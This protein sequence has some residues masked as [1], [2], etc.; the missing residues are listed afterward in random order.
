MLEKY[1]NYYTLSKHP[2]TL[3]SLLL[4]FIRFPLA[5]PG[6]IL[7]FLFSQNFSNVTL[8]ASNVKAQKPIH[9]VYTSDETD[10]KGNVIINL[11]PK[12][13]FKGLKDFWLKFSSSV[14]GV[15]LL[16]KRLLAYDNPEDKAHVD[17]IIEEIQALLEGNSTADKCNGVQFT[18]DE[19]HIKGSEG[20]D[21]KLYAY[22]Y[23]QI[24][25]K[26][27]K[28]LVDQP[29][30]T[31][32]E[33]FTLETPDGAVLDSV[34]VAGDKE[35]LKPIS[36]RKFVVSCMARDQNYVN[37][38][39]DFKHSAKQ[40]GCTVVGF[41]YR[42]IDYSKGMVW[43][44]ENLINDALAQ[45]QRLL[46][47]GA[48]PENIGLEGMSIGGAVATLTAARLHEQGIKVKLYNERSFRSLPRLITGYILPPP[49]SNPWNPI[50]WL[51]YIAAG[52][53][54]AIIL[55]IFWI[56]GW[57]MDAGSAW[58]KI[59]QEYKNFSVA[60]DH[61]DYDS[62]NHEED[63]IIHDSWAS[64]A[65]LVDENKAAIGRKLDHGTTINEEE[66]E[67]LFDQ[68]ENHEFRVSTSNED[69]IKRR[70]HHVPR[71]H[72]VNSHS[73][74]EKMHDH[75]I[76]DF[77][78]KFGPQY[79]PLETSINEAAIQPQVSPKIKR[80]LL[81]ASSGGGGHI[82]SIMGIIDELKAD[83][84][85]TLELTDHKAQ[86]YQHKDFSW[87]GLGVKIAAGIMSVPL[88]GDFIAFI[89]KLMGNPSLPNWSQL[90]E[91][92]NK[93]EK[94]ETDTCSQ[95]PMGRTRPYVDMLLDVMPIGYESAAIWN[96]LLRADR[97]TDLD[98]L[99]KQ[100]AQSDKLFYQTAYQA[101][102]K[103]LIDAAEKG[104]AYTEIISTQPLALDALCD[105]VLF[106]N[107]NYLPQINAE[108]TSPLPEVAIHQFLTD[109]P[110]L[111]CNHFLDSIANLSPEQQQQMHV[112]AVNFTAGVVKSYFADGEHFKGIHTLSPKANPMIRAG[113][114]DPNLK[115]YLDTSKEVVLKVK[116]YKNN[117][118]DDWTVQA[119]KKAIIIP[120]NAKVASIMLG[121]QASDAT[122]IYVKH[123]LESDINYDKIFV[124]GGINKSIYQPIEDIINTYPE[125]QRDSVRNRIVR[126]GNQG[127][128]EIAPIMTRSDCVVIRGGGLSVMEQMALPLN[129]NKKFLFHHQDKENKNLTSGLSWEDGNVDRLIEYLTAKK[130]FA[131]KTSPRLARR[132]L[133]EAKGTEK[134]SPYNNSLFPAL[135]VETNDSD[136]DSYTPSNKGSRSSSPFFKPRAMSR[137]ENSSA[138]KSDQSFAVS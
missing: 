4:S 124:F 79:E 3:G 16:T 112:Y 83:K 13:S 5:L 126:L 125:S 94:A 108:L 98:L 80:P 134:K 40:I 8:N 133:Q 51:R 14:F 55:P 31:K 41:N 17:K 7:S 77:S 18:L 87:L 74:S 71:R 78:D 135:I 56:V 72:L 10:E 21:R 136:T 92:I 9:L 38:I 1:R 6:W 130:V 45:V 22:F 37:W 106:Y 24:Y 111:D 59:P 23:E 50:N 85:T 75:M 60:R 122:V 65:S 121:S 123:L 100:K 30:K 57:H 26:Y 69:Y 102:L 116:D 109:L 48:K 29:K 34:E 132:T 28:Q 58:N 118:S 11:L 76:K 73:K 117:D 82:S 81:I 64:I 99:V 86:L 84:E 113:F 32:L 103:M 61:S 127:D 67:L 90:Q 62:E 43:T 2:K 95:M 107:K 137:D 89:A 91:E 88:L 19:L 12:E 114:K 44:Q 128:A 131:Q 42:G 54:H 15:P 101:S 46:A 104:E 35:H 27:G 129:P 119:E 47:L 25:K 96:V 52:I 97:A 63:G 20:L 115:E 33:F 53:V 36:E 68:D 105:A 110:S 70:P 66:Q 120:S 93:L 138:P 39:K 49:N